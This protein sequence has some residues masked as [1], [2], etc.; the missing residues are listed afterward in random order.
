MV[1][2]PPDAPP[3]LTYAE[4]ALR[5]HLVRLLEAGLPLGRVAQLADRSPEDIKRILHGAW[6]L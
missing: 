5:P 6:R 4:H 2:I 3:R 1:R